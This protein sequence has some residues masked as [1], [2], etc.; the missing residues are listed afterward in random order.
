MGFV[1]VLYENGVWV[2][3]VVELYLCVFICLNCIGVDKVSWGIM[4]DSFVCFIVKI[5]NYRLIERFCICGFCVCECVFFIV[6]LDCLISI[7][8]MD[9]FIDFCNINLI[10]IVFSIFVWVSVLGFEN[11]IKGMFDLE[12]GIFEDLFLVFIMLEVGFRNDNCVVE[13]L[14][15]ILEEWKLV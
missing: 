8:V 15:L 12:V 4:V 2:W 14:G 5:R 7:L 13:F 11:G 1:N 6:I 10:F 3:I 9:F